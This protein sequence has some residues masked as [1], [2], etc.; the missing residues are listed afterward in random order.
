MIG[1]GNSG[2]AVPATLLTVQNL[3]R[4]V[5]LATVMNCIYGLRFSA[6]VGMKTK[7]FTPFTMGPM[8]EMFTKDAAVDCL[9]K[10]W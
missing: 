6:C 5:M 9:E 7:V 2:E 1:G 10:G 8:A 3:T 4:S